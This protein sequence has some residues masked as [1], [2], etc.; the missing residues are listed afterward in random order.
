MDIATRHATGQQAGTAATIAVIAAAA[1]FIVTFA[2][3]PFW[4]LFVQ[5]LAIVSGVFGVLMS[6][7]PKVGGGLASVVAIVLGLIGVGVATL[8]MVGAIIF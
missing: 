8:G 5:V 2:G 4:G 1:G 7:S 6:A 3:H